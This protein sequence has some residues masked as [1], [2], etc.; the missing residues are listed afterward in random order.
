MVVVT[1]TDLWLIPG[2][3]HLLLALAGFNL[4]RFTLRVDG[5]RERARRIIGSLVAVVVR[6]QPGLPAAPCSPATTGSPPPSTSTAWL[7]SESWSPDWQFW[8]LEALVWAYLGVAALLAL[9]RVDRWQR[10]HPFTTAMLLVG[11]ALVAR[12]AL[13][14][15]HAVGTEK[16]SLPVVLW[17]L[18]LGWAAAEARSQAQRVLVATTA[19]PAARLLR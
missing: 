10:T 2:G 4:A 18:A 6:H 5:R 15:V 1:H 14:G 7:G 12:Y 19:A 17:V 8:F 3:A 9:R 13:V 16:Y 11:A